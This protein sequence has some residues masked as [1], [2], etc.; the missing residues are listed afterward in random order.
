[1][2]K[3]SKVAVIVTAVAVPLILILCLVL[4]NT[5]NIEV[6]LGD[7]ALTVVADFYEDLTLS[8]TDI[9][10]VAYMENDR[11]TRQYGF[12]SLRLDMGVYQ[13]EALGTHTRYAYHKCHAAV[14][15]TATDGQIL[16]LNGIDE[17]A[18]KALYSSLREKVGS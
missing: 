1:M 13:N 12:G 9:S 5:G 6:K 18:T 7:E 4:M 3:K 15:I 2:A 17:D 10:S 16:V 11:A 8:Y 14:V